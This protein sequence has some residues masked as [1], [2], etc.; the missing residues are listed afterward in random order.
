MDSVNTN[1]E[2]NFHVVAIPFALLVSLEFTTTVQWRF[3]N[4]NLFTAL[5]SEW[6]EQ[7]SWHFIPLKTSLHD[8]NFPSRQGNKS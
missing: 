4:A 2:D 3:R 7:L 5:W 6:D 1:L 8:P